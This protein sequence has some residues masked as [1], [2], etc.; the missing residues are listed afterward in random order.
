MDRKEKIDCIRRQKYFV[1]GD[2]AVFAAAAALVILFFLLSFINSAAQ[3]E[4][5]VNS[6]AQGETFSV[7][8][9]GEEIFRATLAE[10][11]DYVFYIEGTAGKVTLYEEGRVYSDYNV[12]SVRE[13][14][15][16]VSASDCPDHT[17]RYF[18]SI[19]KGDIL[20]LP[21]DLHIR[22]DGKGLETDV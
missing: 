14:K 17:C 12:I 11:A 21:H 18:G 20:C 10:N 16:G 3:G 5:F 4:T 8:Y 9:R 7:L 19:A 13:G 1:W 15:V 22:I 2:V 6:A